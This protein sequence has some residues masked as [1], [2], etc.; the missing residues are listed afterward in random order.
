MTATYVLF[1]VYPKDGMLDEAMDNISKKLTP[2]GM[3]MEDIAFGIKTIKVLFK[4]DDENTGSSSIEKSLKEIKGVD[5]VEVL[6]E[7]LM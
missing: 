7:S 2:T 1:R 5:E 3:Q 6:E 4:F